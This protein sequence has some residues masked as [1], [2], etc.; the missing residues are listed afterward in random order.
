M[1]VPL[2]S[3]T[4]EVAQ[5]C[6]EECR[7]DQPPP[8]SS[9]VTATDGTLTFTVTIANPTQSCAPPTSISSGTGQRPDRC[10]TSLAKTHRPSP[11]A[12]MARPATAAASPVCCSAGA[13]KGMAPSMIAPSV[14]ASANTSSAHRCR[15]TAPR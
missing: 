5:V 8:S 1:V 9:A 12:V 6:S 7:N 11:Y 14:K 10:L 4:T 3:G 15:S 13:R 2:A